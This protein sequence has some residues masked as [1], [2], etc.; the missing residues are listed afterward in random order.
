MYF[1]SYGDPDRLLVE[2]DEA[3]V[4]YLRIGLYQCILCPHV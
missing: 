3:E 2:L 4:D 1:S